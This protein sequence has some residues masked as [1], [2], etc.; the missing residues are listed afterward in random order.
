MVLCCRLQ[1]LL[2]AVAAESAFNSSRGTRL[3]SQIYNEKKSQFEIKRNNPKDLVERVARDISKLL[4]SKR[5]ALEW[6]TS[7]P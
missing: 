5:K 1:I 6:G 2:R 4:N 3:I 7:N